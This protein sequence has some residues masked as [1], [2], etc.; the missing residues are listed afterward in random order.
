MKHATSRLQRSATILSP[1][2]GFE[3][4]QI[5]NLGVA[6]DLHPVGVKVDHVAGYHEAELLDP[7]IIDLLGKRA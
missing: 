6:E 5:G 3:A 1:S 7:R 4:P 2:S